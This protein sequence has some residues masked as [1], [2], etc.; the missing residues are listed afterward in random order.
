MCIRIIGSGSE[1]KYNSEIPL[2]NQ[3]QDK[4]VIIKYDPKDPDIDKFLCEMERLCSNGISA[5]VKVDVIH[6]DCLNGIKAKKQIKRL[7]KDLNL[8]E[9][10][11]LLTTL[12]SKTDK[13][14]EE[15]S[16]FCQKQIGK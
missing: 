9:A 7:S 2:E 16:L 15:L 12:H 14:L 8:N 1:D 5:N 3:I 6:N 13:A 10:I 11:K 4:E